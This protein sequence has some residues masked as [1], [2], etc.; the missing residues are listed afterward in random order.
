MSLAAVGLLG[1]FAG[2]SRPRNLA[3]VPEDDR[4]ELLSVV[5]VADP[6]AAVQLASGF[7]GLENDSWR[8]T[9]GRFTVVLRPPAGAAQAGAKLE[10]RLT[11][12]EA[13]V[14]QVGPVVL[15]ASVNGLALEQQSF[16]EAGEH[17]FTRLV[18]AAALLESGVAVEFAV[19]KSMRP[20][21]GDLRE[22]AVIVTQVGLTLP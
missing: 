16:S 17:V 4:E 21:G 20:R 9:A 7:W 18:P 12:P 1:A 5:R 10:L 3:V 13:V 11:L 15:R 8:W 19:D 2:C 6:Q 14:A 22:L